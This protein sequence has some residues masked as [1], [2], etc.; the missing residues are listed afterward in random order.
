[1]S[2]YKSQIAA[3]LKTAI[4]S[5]TV[6]NGYSKTVK[7]V[8]F[9]RVKINIAEYQDFEL[10]AVQII[11][12]S[13][14]INHER[15]RS[16]TSWFLVVEICMRTTTGLGIID[17]KALWDLQE[18]IV[19]AIMAKPKLDL[20]FVVH[21]KIID[22]VTDLHLSDPNYIANI[23]IEIMYYEPITSTSC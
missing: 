23:G 13:S 1:M 2:G 12:L 7:T 22:E 17:Q 5:V 20:N 15:S 6:A 11:D 8:S 19:R 9:D 3:K 4:E 18:D 10:P 21:A 16:L 14:T